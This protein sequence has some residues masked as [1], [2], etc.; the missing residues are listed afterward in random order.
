[1]AKVTIKIKKPTSATFRSWSF[2]LFAGLVLTAIAVLDSGR[3]TPPPLVPAADGS[4]GCQFRVVVTE[5]ENGRRV[6]NV[7]SAPDINASIKGTLPDGTLVD[8][9]GKPTNGFREL[10]GGSSWASADHLTLVSGN[11]CG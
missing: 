9:I 2:V 11:D 8:T 1:M 3:L 4:T 10:E 5:T 7:R 6:L